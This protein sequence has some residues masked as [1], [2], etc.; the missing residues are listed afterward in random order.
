[1]D[2]WPPDVGG[3]CCRLHP[4]PDDGLDIVERVYDVHAI[5]PT[6]A[7]VALATI[8]KGACH[9]RDLFVRDN[10]SSGSHENLG[11]GVEIQWYEVLS[12]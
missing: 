3:A 11:V 7:R 10:P 9:M 2:R 12:G 8:S 4:A 6:P 5:G 1:M